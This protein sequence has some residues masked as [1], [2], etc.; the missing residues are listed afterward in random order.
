MDTMFQPSLSDCQLKEI[1]RDH[2]L[3][4]SQPRIALLRYIMQNYHHPKAETVFHDLRPDNP[5]LSLTT[6]Y[7]TLRLFAENGLC[8]MLT[9]DDK[10]VFYDGD[11][12]PHGHFMCVG[13]GR[14]F[15][16]PG[17]I[18]PNASKLHENGM[19][20]FQ[21]HEMHYYLKGTCNECN[22]NI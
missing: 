8:S 5:T 19:D 21:V 11:T 17:S 1:L 10:H 12:K 20:G 9:I 13:C 2:N 4:V 18:M 14:I 3:T 16:I 7:N 22:E 15:D 6:V